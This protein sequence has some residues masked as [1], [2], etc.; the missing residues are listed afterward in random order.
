MWGGGFL[1][2]VG[3]QEGVKDF[4]GEYG[5]VV[6]QILVEYLL[7]MDEKHLDRAEMGSFLVMT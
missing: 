7:N 2:A 4:I 3:F 1:W 6:I 5:V